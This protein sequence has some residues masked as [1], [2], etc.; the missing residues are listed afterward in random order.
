MAVDTL[1]VVQRARKTVE[2]IDRPGQT[3]F[4]RDVLENCGNSCVLTG[5]TLTDVLIACHI[6]EVKDGGSDHV[7]NGIALRSDLHILFDSNK[8]RLDQDCNI[9][10]S[11][12][13]QLSAIYG[14]L[15][16]QVNLPAN[17]NATALR[18]RHDYGSVS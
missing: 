8:L 7:S 14:Q 18:L 3:K 10:L 1:V 5:E 6:H 12:D 11:P 15:P 13:V 4:R 16:A 2:V 9:T 17:L